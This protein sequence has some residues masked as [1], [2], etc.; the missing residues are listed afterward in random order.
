M[1]RR[2]DGY[3]HFFRVRTVDDHV[4]GYLATV[5][6]DVNPLSGH[7]PEVRERPEAGT[8]QLGGPVLAPAAGPVVE[9]YRV[10]GLGAVR[11]RLDRGY[12]AGAE[13]TV[14]AGRRANA[15]PDD[16]PLGQP[17]AGASGQSVPL[18]HAICRQR[19]Q[20]DGGR[21]TARL[22]LLRFAARTRA[23]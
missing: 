11:G 14:V 20:L 23:I 2:R 19:V 13:F 5:E 9:P 18:P 21:D 3:A 7:Q 16:R 6:R 17:F 1:S 22:R 4:A 15:R 12:D 8:H 10:A